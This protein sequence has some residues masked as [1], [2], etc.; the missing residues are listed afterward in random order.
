M[1]LNPTIYKKKTL[2]IFGAYLSKIF[3]ENSFSKILYILFLKAFV[4]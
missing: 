4:I 1:T 3:H 2:K